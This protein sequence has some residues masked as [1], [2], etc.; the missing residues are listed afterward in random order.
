MRQRET[1]PEMAPIPDINPT[2]GEYKKLFEAKTGHLLLTRL[3]KI[4]SWL[5]SI[6]AKYADYQKA[7][8]N[9]EQWK[10]LNPRL[11]QSEHV[12]QLNLEI[13]PKFSK[14]K[15]ELLSAKQAYYEAIRSAKK[16]RLEDHERR[17]VVSQIPVWCKHENQPTPD[18]ETLLFPDLKFSH[19]AEDLKNP[20]AEL[21]LNPL[22]YLFTLSQMAADID[23]R[24]RTANSKKGNGNNHT[25]L[26]LIKNT[27]DSSSDAGIQ[28]P[29]EEPDAK[30]EGEYY[31]EGD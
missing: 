23:S 13:S 24:L 30:G 6:K 19:N 5:N 26:L 17:K 15:R 25:P 10:N 3:E 18:M 16:I 14:A 11:P 1:G 8:N 9:F 20:N 27:P 2:N 21:N 4:I 31:D 22:P 7:K 12:T 29:A 28:D